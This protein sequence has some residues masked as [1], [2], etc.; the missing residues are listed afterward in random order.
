MFFFSRLTNLLG[1]ELAILEKDQSAE[2]KEEPLIFLDDDLIV[3]VLLV[4][5]KV[6]GPRDNSVP[7]RYI[8]WLLSCTSIFFL[9]PQL[10]KY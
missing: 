1:D 7:V 5:R 4:H 3:L 8:H 10:L 6:P 2:A 9:S